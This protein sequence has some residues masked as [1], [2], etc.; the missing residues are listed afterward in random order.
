MR[1]RFWIAAPSCSSRNRAG[2]SRGI[3]NG[4]NDL[5]QINRRSWERLFSG[6]Q[7]IS[8]CIVAT[9]GKYRYTL[10]WQVIFRP[11]TR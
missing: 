9:D 2:S 11:G 10:T 4:S 3:P 1:D 6:W 7:R 5:A 8:S